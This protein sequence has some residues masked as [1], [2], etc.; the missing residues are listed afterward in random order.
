MKKTT[1]FLLVLALLCVS[2]A[3]LADRELIA[4]APTL[5]SVSIGPDSI[6]VQDILNFADGHLKIDSM[7]TT[8]N[9]G[10]YRKFTGTADAE[11]VV[12]AYIGILS[13]GQYNLTMADSKISDYRGQ[14]FYLARYAFNYLGTARVS[15]VN[16][17][18]GPDGPVTLWYN[19][20]G[21]SLSGYVYVGKGLEFGDLGLRFG[22]GTADTSLPGT[23]LSA[24]LYRL[25]DGSY[26]TGDGR[27]HVGLNQ[28]VVYRDGTPYTVTASLTRNTAKSREELR[29]Y[30]FY[31]N[32]SI[33]WTIPYNYPMT[34]DVFSG[35]QLAPELST[36]KYERDA[37]DME[38]LLHW[39]FSNQI[40]GVCHD[41]DYLFFYSDGG[42]DFLKA[43]VRV[44]NWDVNRGEAVI[45]LCC[46]FDS[47]PYEFEA[48]AVVSMGPTPVGAD[49][50]KVFTM[51]AGSTVDIDFDGTEFGTHYELFTWEILEG[52]SLIELTGT[53]NQT[54]TVHAHEPGQ[55]RLKVTY[56]YGV[57]GTDVL[58]GNTT[59]DFMS[60]TREYVI[61]IE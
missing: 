17:S 44:M 40:L 15:N 16:P 47:A 45:Y 58:T 61:V 25:D 39:T 30:N 33:L 24:D 46:E 6:Y 48:M 21:N 2:T 20:D 22:G 1:L 18:I 60:K 36:G 8:D 14:R 38:D 9:G 54:C 29:V 49:A 4:P 32:E 52:S 12:V 34:G 28:A 55:V 51:K 13:S 10:Q 27:F 41:G 59:T 50:D 31:R 5:N 11:E 23:S 43:A 19:V 57:D 56:E 35:R 53:R 3:A 7:K 26:E 42:N 37:H